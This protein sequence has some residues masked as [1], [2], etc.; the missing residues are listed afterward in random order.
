MTGRAGVC[1]QQCGHLA[2][3]FKSPHR[4]NFE[5]GAGFY[6]ATQTALQKAESPSSPLFCNVCSLLTEGTIRAALPCVARIAPPEDSFESGTPRPFKRGAD[7]NGQRGP[8][9]HES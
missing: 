5:L 2:R 7:P 3:L 1:P 6:A 9:E 4:S 8:Q